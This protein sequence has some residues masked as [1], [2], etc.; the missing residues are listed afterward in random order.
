MVNI[1]YV[2]Y[3]EVLALWA[4][5]VIVTTSSSDSHILDYKSETV[6]MFLSF[7]ERGETNFETVEM[8]AVGYRNRNVPL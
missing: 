1:G 7:K 8:S 3:K 4:Q 6:F 5:Q 2:V